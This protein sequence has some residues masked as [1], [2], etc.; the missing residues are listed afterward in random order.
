MA[1]LG[2]LKVCLGECEMRKSIVTIIDSKYNAASP[3]LLSSG[4]KKKNLL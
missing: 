2:P 3:T 1:E 4:P